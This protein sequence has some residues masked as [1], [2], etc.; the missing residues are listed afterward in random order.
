VTKSRIDQGAIRTEVGRWVERPG[1]IFGSE[2]SLDFWI[3]LN[4]LRER[5]VIVS[6][7]RDDRIDQLTRVEDTGPFSQHRHHV[8]GHDEP[9]GQLEVPA[10]TLFVNL[11]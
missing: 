11:E 9:T 1:E 7:F 2:M 10:H 4:Q 8:L 5:T 6:G 3:F